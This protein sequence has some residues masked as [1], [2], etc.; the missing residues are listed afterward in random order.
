MAASSVQQLVEILN[1]RFF[2]QS[3]SL[4]IMGLI[5]VSRMAKLPPAKNRLT[6]PAMPLIKYGA[7]GIKL[8]KL[9]RA[10]LQRS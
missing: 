2:V 8:K 10:A 7:V 1:H 4:F 6:K 9:I 3:K 5:H